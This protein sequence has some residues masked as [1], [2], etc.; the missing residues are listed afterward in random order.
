LRFLA[1]YVAVQNFLGENDGFIGYDGMNNFYF[2]RKEN[3]DQHIL[4]AWDEDN[5]FWGPTFDLATRHDE[6]VLFRKMMEV[7][8]LRDLYYATLLEAVHSAQEPAEGSD[9]AWLDFEIRRQL[10]LID[11]PLS[12]DT[13]KPYTNDDHA[14]HRT[15]MI[16]FATERPRFVESNLP[17]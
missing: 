16:I 12:Q 1:R 11:E 6:N 17:R 5:A 10:D 2:Y 7:R 15:A 9:E 13:K 14:F 3:S 4:I 8:E